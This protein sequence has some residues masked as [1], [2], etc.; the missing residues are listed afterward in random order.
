MQIKGLLKEIVASMHPFITEETPSKIIL[1]SRRLQFL[2]PREL[3]TLMLH[4]GA[5]SDSVSEVRKIRYN[6]IFLY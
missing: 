2:T 6:P 3:T 5:F 1:L 4:Y